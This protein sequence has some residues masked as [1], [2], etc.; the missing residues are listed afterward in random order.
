MC[1]ISLA[2]IYNMFPH[3][4]DVAVGAPYEGDG[5]VYIFRGYPKGIRQP[6]SQRIAASDLATARTLTSFGSSVSGGIDMDKNGF[7]FMVKY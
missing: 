7:V 6:F 4:T 2:E 5:A 1:T 3:F